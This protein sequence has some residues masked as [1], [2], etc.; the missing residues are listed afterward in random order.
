MT[1][2]I[3]T[4]RDVL[5]VLSSP[6]RG[7][8]RCTNGG[9]YN[10]NAGARTAC[11]VLLALDDLGTAATL[12]ASAA[13]A[14]AHDTATAVRVAEGMTGL[15]LAALGE[16]EREGWTLTARLAIETLAAELDRDHAREARAAALSDRLSAAGL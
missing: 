8:H 11:P 1:R 16:E 6:H 4:I 3:D 9:W 15:D 2:P 7:G 13:H 5:T 12:L 14:A 10:D